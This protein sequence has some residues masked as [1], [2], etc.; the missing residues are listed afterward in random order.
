M[1]D[2]KLLLVKTSALPEIFIKVVEAKRL[3]A[4]GEAKTASEASKKC[5]ISRSAFYK[6]KD[7]VHEYNQHLGKIISLHAVLRDKAGVLSK[8]LLVLYE[9]NANI[10]TVNQGIPASGVASVSVSLRVNAAEFDIAYIV[11]QISAING[12]VSVKQI[13]GE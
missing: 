10:L 7:S 8:L 11:E 12:V 2:T 13:I 4:S 6:Y 9:N 1:T 3:L 5:G